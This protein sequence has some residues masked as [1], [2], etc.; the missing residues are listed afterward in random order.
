MMKSANAKSISSARLH[1][2]A[3]EFVHLPRYWSPLLKI[4]TF[5]GLRPLRNMI[6]LQLLLFNVRKKR[7]II[8]KLR[9]LFIHELKPALMSLSVVKSFCFISKAFLL[10]FDRQFQFE[11]SLISYC[12]FSKSSFYHSPGTC[13]VS[14]S[15]LRGCSSG[16]INPR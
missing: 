12:R 8:A 15:L 5:Q 10:S 9:T 11:T 4:R 2:G 7:T 6:I 14:F 16:W 13:I 3:S 1:I